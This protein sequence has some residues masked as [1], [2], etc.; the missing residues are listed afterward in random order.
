LA[1]RLAYG[2]NLPSRTVTAMNGAFAR[3]PF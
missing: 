1:S 3:S 2:S